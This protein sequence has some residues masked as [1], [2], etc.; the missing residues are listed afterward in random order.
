[1][2]PGVFEKAWAPNWRELKVLGHLDCQSCN[3]RLYMRGFRTSG[4]HKA[5][6][7]PEW[8]AVCLVFST[9]IYGTLFFALPWCVPGKVFLCSLDGRWWLDVTKKSQGG[10][11]D[12]CV[13]VRVYKC[14]LLPIECCALGLKVKAI[15]WLGLNIK[16]IIKPSNRDRIKIP[17]KRKPFEAFTNGLCADHLRRAINRHEQPELILVPPPVVRYLCARSAGDLGEILLSS[18]CSILQGTWTIRMIPTL[19]FAM[20][21]ACCTPKKRF[22]RTYRRKKCGTLRIERKLLRFCHRA[23]GVAI[24]HDIA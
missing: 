16:A 17:I 12:V 11:V 4:D 5:Y 2:P 24:L 19:S 15:S 22:C 21:R 20:P 8:V 18:S 13:C 10:G 3:S 9:W 23:F 14:K 7:M 1:M 6:Y